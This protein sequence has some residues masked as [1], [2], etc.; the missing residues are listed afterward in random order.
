M[1]PAK[2]I[3]VFGFMRHFPDE[4]AAVAFV[5][6]QMWGGHRFARIAAARRPK[7]DFFCGNKCIIPKFFNTFIV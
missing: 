5:E 3:S 6:K 7:N 2:T 4:R 1:K